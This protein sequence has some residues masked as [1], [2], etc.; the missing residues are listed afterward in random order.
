MEALASLVR[1]H[2]F[3][4]RLV[5]ALES[6]AHRVGGGAEV[7][8]ADV[9]GLARAL[10]QYADELHREKEEHVLLP[11][12]ARHGFDWDAPLL[13]QVRE[14]HSRERDLI[15]ALEHAG[16]GLERWT[17]EERRHVAA[18]ASSLCELQRRHHQAENAQLF[19]A[20]IE[21]LDAQALHG[22]QGELDRFDQ[23]PLHIARRAAASDLGDELIARYAELDRAGP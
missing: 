14:E 5:T 4:T 22:L 7:D 2:Q 15:A 3:I 10:R 6:C 12:L 13:V 17:G 19:P 9:R 1:E 20:I 21:R 18:I 11:F 8:P 16:A 23:H